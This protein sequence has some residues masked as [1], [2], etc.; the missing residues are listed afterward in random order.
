MGF[1]VAGPNSQFLRVG[2][3]AYV[4]T[5]MKAIS[6]LVL[7]CPNLA[8]DCVCVYVCMYEAGTELILRMM[9]VCETQQ[10]LS[11]PEGELSCRIK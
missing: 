3:L 7:S 2:M 11:C 10:V 9:S 8:Y 6:R 4:S 1:F 5:Y